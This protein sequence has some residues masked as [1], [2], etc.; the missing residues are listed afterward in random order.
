MFLGKGVGG[1]GERL[2]MR[3]CSKEI[4]LD[5]GHDPPLCSDLKLLTPVKAKQVESELD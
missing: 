4:D 1:K 5:K 3:G 2:S